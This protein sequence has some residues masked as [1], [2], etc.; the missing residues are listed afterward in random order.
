MSEIECDHLRM[1]PVQCAVNSHNGVH[2][3][4]VLLALVP[5]EAVDS[6][7]SAACQVWLKSSCSRVTAGLAVL[8]PYSRTHW[9]RDQ[10]ASR[11][12]RVG[13]TPMG[14]PVHTEPL[15]FQR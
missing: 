11:N 4:G 8:P 6:G 1:T 10:H 7:G 3:L 12:C 14:L 5:D 13:D 2:D 15:S 9:R